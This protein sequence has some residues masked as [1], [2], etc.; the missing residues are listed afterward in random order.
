MVAAAF[1]RLFLANF[2]NLGETV[3]VSHRILTV[4]P[5]IVLLYYLSARLRNGEGG[6]AGRLGGAAPAPVS[7]TRPQSSPSSSFA[8]RLVAPW[9]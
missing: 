1:G 8:S 9:P 4:L 2:T 3:G 7:S 6:R 5:F